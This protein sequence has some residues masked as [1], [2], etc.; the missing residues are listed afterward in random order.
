MGQFVRSVLRFFCAVLF[1]F[2]WMGALWAQ[3]E[4]PVPWIDRAQIRVQTQ[5]DAAWLELGEQK[6][7]WRWD[8][9]F[10]GQQGIA[11]LE[12]SFD[13]TRYAQSQSLGLGAVSTGLGNRY[14]YQVN[15]GYW[16]EQGWTEGSSHAR[17]G[18]QWLLLSTGDLQTGLNTLRV[19][20]RAE[21]A[22]EAGF[23]PLYLGDEHRT[24][25]YYEQIRDR[26]MAS[27]LVVAVISLLTGVWVL[28]IWMVNRGA[29]FLYSGL[30][31][32]LFGTRQLATLVEYPPMPT[33]VWNALSA[34]F[35]ALYVGLVCKSSLHLTQNASLKLKRL[36]DVY[37]WAS[38][39][40]LGLGFALG[41]PNAYKLWAGLMVLMTLLHV[42]HLTR[43]A[44]REDDVAVKLF[45]LAGWSAL[46][47]GAWDFVVI[48]WMPDGLGRWRMG[49]YA[50]L[51]FNLS[52]TWMVIHRFMLTQKQLIDTRARSQAAAESA[53][54]EERQRIMADLHDS[55][56][57][58]LVGIQSM[59]QSHQTHEAVGE[60]V[61]HALDELRLTVDALQPMHGRLE[62]VLASLRH[63][64]APRLQAA[65]L[66]LVWHVDALPVFD[67]LTPPHVQHI[68]KIVL[69]ALSNIIRHARA[70]RVEIRVTHEAGA[71][72]GSGLCKISIADDGCGMS[73]STTQ[74]QGL[75]NMQLRADKLGG[76][77]FI[78]SQPGQGTSVELTLPV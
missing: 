78:R 68:Q 57:A 11:A 15:D 65:G 42:G 19:E 59:L 76:Q 23:A 3:T 53:K 4:E 60:Q 31:E 21:S 54:F 74:G 67:G 5:A 6:L 27:T 39:P 48:Q 8:A 43:Q 1:G 45:A 71:H 50:S 22:N 17:V 72:T 61:G 77:L 58:Q 33:W 2:V 16:I 75:R 26:R 73:D 51:L 18:P 47:V 66:T 52:L 62:V 64:I 69:E 49:T 32:V 36:G 13:S 41:N 35:F 70:K 25:R 24:G 44:K 34:I 63:R 12:L 55:V 30:A 37:L 10:A 14:R 40:V 56:G 28:G 9:S 38:V 29:V 46:L 7:P 20:I